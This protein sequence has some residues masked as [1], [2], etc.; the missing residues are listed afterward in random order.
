MTAAY[1]PAL[2]PPAVP[3]ITCDPYFSIWSFD[4]ELHG[5]TTR[6]WTGAAHPLVLWVKIDDKVYRVMGAAAHSLPG[7]EQLGLEVLPTQTIY[8]FQ[9][10]G[11]RLTLRFTT[12]M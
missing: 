1:E 11:I 6:H 7:M 12:P 10:S 2:R 9:S 4:D 8:R 3:L 5:G